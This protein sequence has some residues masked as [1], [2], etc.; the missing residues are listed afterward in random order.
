MA[1]T[2]D[3]PVTFG[4]HIHVLR[5]RAG[6]SMQQFADKLEV[7]KD[8]IRALE[9]GKF[10]GASVSSWS[11]ELMEQLSEILPGFS[12]A[13]APGVDPPPMRKEQIEDDVK[14]AKRLL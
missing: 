1:V 6:Y 12:R 14:A 5:K 11:E 8:T 4:R 7:P 10:R 2:I 13:L 3:N 9:T